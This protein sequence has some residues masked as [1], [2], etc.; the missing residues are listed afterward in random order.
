MTI[1]ALLSDRRVGMGFDSD[2]RATILYRWLVISVVFLDAISP[3]SRDWWPDGIDI[4]QRLL[5]SAKGAA[6][7]SDHI[8][9]NYI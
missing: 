4:Q 8:M 7:V 1:A 2:S 9:K 6:G 3:A 5:L